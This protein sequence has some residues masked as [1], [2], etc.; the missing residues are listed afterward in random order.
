VIHWEIVGIRLEGVELALWAALS[1]VLQETAASCP[2]EQRPVRPASFEL[3]IVGPKQW[4][5]G[6]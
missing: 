6:R 4:T 1:Y 5:A 2:T 3:D